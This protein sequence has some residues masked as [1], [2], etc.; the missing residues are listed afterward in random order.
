[1]AARLAVWS[2][3]EIPPQLNEAIPDARTPQRLQGWITEVTCASAQHLRSP[4]ALFDLFRKKHWWTEPPGERA[5]QIVVLCYKP[6]LRD[7]AN[8]TLR[9]LTRQRPEGNDGFWTPLWVPFAKG[10]EADG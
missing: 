6:W 10:G 9:R 1:M 3:Q 7:R 2:S 5:F 8:S 4:D